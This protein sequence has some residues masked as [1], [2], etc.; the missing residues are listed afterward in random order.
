M[1]HLYRPR[2]QFLYGNRNGYIALIS[3]MIISTLV[4]LIATSASLL[5]LS[6]SGMSL[7][8]TQAWQ[9]Y[10]LADFCT[11]YALIKLESVL[12]YAGETITVGDGFCNISLGGTGNFNR[13][14]ETQSA[15]LGQTRKIKVEISQ[16]SPVMQI[17]SWQQVVSF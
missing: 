1:K 3:V 16:V 2:R 11:E 14:I 7:Q 12:D 6:E 10:Y 17:T 13:V 4:V 9:S 15:V 5:S 8:E